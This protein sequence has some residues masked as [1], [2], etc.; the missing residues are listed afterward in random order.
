MST[1]AGLAKNNNGRFSA[2]ERSEATSAISLRS[3]AGQE[4]EVLERLFEVDRRWRSFKDAQAP[5]AVC[6]RSARVRPYR[7]GGQL[8]RS[9][10]AQRCRSPLEAAAV[11][12][13]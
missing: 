9:H 1:V 10:P 6:S 12:R 11:G 7:L 13:D 2:M 3:N 5:R 4:V 8:A